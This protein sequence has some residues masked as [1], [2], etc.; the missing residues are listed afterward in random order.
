M[1]KQILLIALCILMTY[2]VSHE[3][4]GISLLIEWM[5]ESYDEPSLSDVEGEEFEDH[6]FTSP[7]TEFD[8]DHEKPIEIGDPNLNFK[9]FDDPNAADFGNLKVPKPKEGWEITH[10]R[11]TKKFGKEF[12]HVDNPSLLF[13]PK[14]H[15]SQEECLFH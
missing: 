8:F 11:D 15:K 7:P 5:M 9:N 14:I 4:S 10:E 2:L 13:Y 3:I 6:M 1:S 12:I